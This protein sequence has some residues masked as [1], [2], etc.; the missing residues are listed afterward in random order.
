[1]NNHQYENIYNQ[2][3]QAS[4]TNQLVVFIGAGM[5]NNFG[6]PTWNGLIKQIYGELMGEETAADSSLI[7]MNCCV[8]RRH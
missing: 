3:A 2:I 4:K 5:S 1:M 6:F 7:M 8:L